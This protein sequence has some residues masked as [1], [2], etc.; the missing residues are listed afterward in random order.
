MYQSWEQRRRAIDR[1]LRHPWTECL[2][3]GLISLS[4]MLVI[5][6]VALGPQQDQAWIIGVGNL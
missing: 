4:V 5:A 6:E 1:F 2:L 3:M